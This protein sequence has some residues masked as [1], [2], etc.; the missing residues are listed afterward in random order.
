MLVLL[1]L[2]KGMLGNAGTLTEVFHVYFGWYKYISWTKDIHQS[3]SLEELSYKC[4]QENTYTTTQ[5]TNSNTITT[6]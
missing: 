2:L 1:G 3:L 5:S 4:T 6:C